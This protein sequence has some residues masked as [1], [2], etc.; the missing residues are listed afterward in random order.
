MTLRPRKKMGFSVRTMHRKKEPT[1]LHFL[2]GKIS[3]WIATFSICAFVVG[4][5]VGQH[6]WY[7]FWKSVLGQVDDSAIIYTGT[8]TP[9]EKVPDLERWAAYG[10]DPS[11]HTFRQIPEDFLIPLPLYDSALMK[12]TDRAHGHGGDVYSVGHMGSYSSGAEGSGSHPGIDIRVPI[13]TP[14][15]TIASGIVT[16]VKHGGGYGKV[17]VVK[18][19]NVPDP[20]NPNQTTTLYSSYAHL[21][22]IYVTKGA[23]LQK[24]EHIADSGATGF[25]SGPHLH[26]QL[27]RDEA[28]WHPYWPF[29]GT[30]ARNEG[31]TL[32][33]AVNNG[34]FKPRGF[35]YTV[36]PMLY[37][38][39]DYPRPETTIVQEETETQV[40]GA[41]AENTVRVT[42]AD[43]KAKRLSRMLSR[44]EQRI[45]AR[46]A[47]RGAVLPEVKHE[48]AAAPEEEPK[49]N[50]REAVT[51]AIRHDGDFTVDQA[52]TVWI[53]L[54][55][56][57]GN[58]IVDPILNTEL[59][60]QTGYGDA[61]FEPHILTPASFKNG[62]AEVKVWPK[63]RRTVVI[64]LQPF[65][66]L[67]EAMVYKK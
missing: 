59:Y 63:G 35:M 55:N 62:E 66:V 1:S 25:T 48:H 38:Q 33:Q 61:E 49:T 43:R 45:K 2:S 15:R 44:R 42:V 29:T 41:S 52:E 64:Q 3:F 7:A 16:D 4:N 39:A 22:A 8:V 58:H 13:G 67:S 10:G 57:E 50:L 5:M 34:L 37:V 40:A 12:R 30:E 28:P 20:R 56:K 11:V 54:L 6:G 36:N 26:F 27:D 23:V 53:T 21:S 17:V 65:N 19:P 24:G 32:T 14:I 18:H 60:L 31:L 46:L 9:I 47:R 51:A